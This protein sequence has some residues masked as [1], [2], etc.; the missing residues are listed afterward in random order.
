MKQFFVLHV[1][2]VQVCCKEF[3]G[4]SPKINIKSSVCK[5]R[6]QF[7]MDRTVQIKMC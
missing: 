7:Y 3:G 6:K 4:H 1:L 2:E 5:G